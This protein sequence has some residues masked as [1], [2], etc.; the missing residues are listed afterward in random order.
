M[1]C[2][3][4]PTGGTVR[5]GTTDVT[6]MPESKLSAVRLGQIGFVFQAFNLFPTLTAGENVGLALDLT[7]LVGRAARTRATEL[8]ALVGLAD[9]FDKYPNELSGGQKQRVAIA[10]AL[11]N[12][13]PIILA[14]E[15]TA[16]LDSES[17]RQVIELLRAIAHE[18]N[19]AVVIVT[20]DERTVS[21]ADRIVR[22]QDGRLQPREFAA[23]GSL[24]AAH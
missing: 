14:D 5:I 9:H 19:H 23:S 3:I 7:G 11:A 16:A 17:G 2:I 18:R 22:I 8:L 20:H 6:A 13:P 10:R 1:G 15:P 21:Y 12:D 4:R 24:S